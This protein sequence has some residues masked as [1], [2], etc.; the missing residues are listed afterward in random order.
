MLR[1][2]FG[3]EKSSYHVKIEENGVCVSGSKIVLM[4]KIEG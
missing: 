4:E 3:K 1:L 2:I